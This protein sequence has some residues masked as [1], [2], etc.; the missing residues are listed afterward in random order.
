MAPGRPS[1]VPAVGL[2]ARLERLPLAK[3]LADLDRRARTGGA[4]A[5]LLYGA[6][7]DR[8][9]HR[10]SAR[11]AYDRAVA[12]DPES[13]DARTAAA[14]IRFDKDDPTRAFSRLGPLAGD[15]PRAAIVRFHLGLLLLWLPNVE[16]ARRQL[17]LAGQASPETVYGREAKR[18]LARLAQL[19][20]RDEEE[21]Q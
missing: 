5:W 6:A 10:V 20:Q 9:G 7:H 4:R 3:R 18:L 12:L 13:V 21:G 16:E 15:H 19:G 1:F 14:V 11:R 8:L 2:P 17:R